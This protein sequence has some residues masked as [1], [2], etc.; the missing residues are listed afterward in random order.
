MTFE[1]NHLRE[2][3]AF[4]IY[5][6]GEEKYK[7]VSSNVDEH[8]FSSKQEQKQQFEMDS[9]SN[10][11][12]FM[13]ESRIEPKLVKSY[14][15][16]ADTF[17]SGVHKASTESESEAEVAIKRIIVKGSEQ[18]GAFSCEPCPQ[19]TISKILS[20]DCEKCPAGSEP[21]K[22]KTA[23]TPC[24]T[25]TFSNKEGGTCKNCPPFT[26]SRRHEKDPLVFNGDDMHPKA[27]MD[28]TATHCELDEEFHV[29]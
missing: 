4:L 24:K 10:L 13:V 22:N 3:E 18:G 21:N 17:I 15:D 11:I 14:W 9:G 6:N 29:L 8:G 7:V 23:C 26:H 16:T 19:G 20:H 5:I 1:T 27:V 28:S 2:G 12:Q 25:G